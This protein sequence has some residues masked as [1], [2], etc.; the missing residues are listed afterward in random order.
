MR[1]QQDGKVGIGTTNPGYALESTGTSSIGGKALVA[2][3]TNEIWTQPQTNGN[4]ALYI[5]WRGYADASTQFRDLII[6]DGKGAAVATF[7]G[8]AASVGI[9]S[10]SPQAKLHI[11]S[12]TPSLLIDGNGF[13]QIKTS[14]NAG[15]IG[16]WVN[17]G[18][19]AGGGA[20]IRIDSADTIAQGI[21]VNSMNSS[22]D[23]IYVGAN[24]GT[25]SSLRSGGR[26]QFDGNVGI[27]TS[28][29]QAKLHISSGTGAASMIVDGDN[30]NGILVDNS[31]N[32]GTAF[33]MKIL[34]D[35]PNS[36]S[37]THYGLYVIVP[38]TPTGSPGYSR[39]IYANA[40]KT[41]ASA[42]GRTFGIHG[43]AGNGTSGYN[44]GVVG[45]LTGTN[46]G[47]AVQGTVG[48]M[49]EGM[50]AQ[51]AGYFN[52]NTY[53]SG[54]LGVGATTAAQK[55]HVAGTIRQTGCVTAG[56]LSANASGDIICTSDER[57]KDIY[58]P[59]QGGLDAISSI[60]PIRFSYKGEEFVHVGFSAQNVKSVLP[61]ASAMQTSGHWS[62]DNTAVTALTVN[63]IKE[64]KLGQDEL[65]KASGRVPVK[66][67]AEAGPIK[68][69]DPLALSPKAG[70]AMKA[71]KTGRIIGTALE[72]FDGTKPEGEILCFL[73][74][75]TW[76][77]PEEYA[78]LK[79]TV[80]RLAA[81]SAKAKGGK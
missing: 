25:G 60:D 41:T 31:R 46:N 9:G 68:A 30:A 16:L 70:Y 76:I 3:L 79:A 51:Y 38:S 64:L 28:S 26:A 50:G 43:V 78:K 67:T 49:V 34:M 10:A 71:T 44:Q 52:G 19:G 22:E 6:G 74:A 23:S 65:K 72:D 56:T 32:S 13:Q 47:S 24:S 69:G 73:H 29:P 35:A 36:G 48:T 59:Y 66:V 58:G 15:S 77:D 2:G 20:G 11:S 8:S 80:E 57:A 42:G 18:A 63:A 12:G 7:D 21:V 75:T 33:G 27:A 4:A 55:L 45:E 39:G 1:V 40:T 81:E 53:V 37:N 14:G 54:N 17:I 61:E 62:L 5:N